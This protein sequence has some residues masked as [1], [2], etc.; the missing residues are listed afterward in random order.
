MKIAW[1]NLTNGGMSGGSRKYLARIAPRLAAD[2]RVSRLDMLSPAGIKDFPQLTG[3]SSHWQWGPKQ[4]WMGF[5]A[6]RERLKRIAPDIVFVPTA[7]WI[8]P[9]GAGLVIMVRNMEPL[10]PQHSDNPP[11]IR[12]VNAARARAA[13]LACRRADR[14]IAV[15]DFVMQHIESEWSVPA[16][17]VARIYHGLDAAGPLTAPIQPPGFTPGDN[18]PFLFLAGSLRP[19]RGIEDA[20]R[21]F[22]IL[23]KRY[24]KLQLAIAGAPEGRVAD[25]LDHQRALA[26]SLGV[27]TRVRWLGKLNEA[28]MKWCFERS[29]I[30]LMTSRV[31]ACPN[32]A[33]EA[34]GHGAL[35][36]S[37]RNPPM[38]EFFRSAAVYYTAGD[39]ED[40]AGGISRLLD[41]PASDL[42]RLRGKSIELAREFTWDGCAEL[43]LQELERARPPGRLN[44]RAGAER[45]G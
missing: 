14:I 8:D 19:M 2:P 22:G 5:P 29:A 32:T 4:K 1:V 3:L 24:P 42:Q 17:K 10:L 7:R 18:V 44:P 34:L 36:V 25:W 21:G 41:A 16:S 30:F 31:E 13:K 9:G 39:A 6:I 33:L 20:L 15:S 35:I 45:A 11:F 27:A 28:E 23:S 26:T 38:P 12:L 43:T 40:I 37:T